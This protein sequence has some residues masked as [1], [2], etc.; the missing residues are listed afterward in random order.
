MSKKSIIIVIII[1]LL[2]VFLVLNK[3]LYGIGK[4]IYN[5]MNI[6]DTQVSSGNVEVVPVEHASLILKSGGKVIYVDPVYPKS[7]PSAFAGEPAPDLILIT[8]IHPDHF[9]IKTLEGVSKENT[10]IIAPMILADMFPTTVAGNLYIMK[11]GQKT[12]MQG[13]SIESMPMYNLP[14][15]ADSYHPKGRG[16]GYVV[17]IGGKRVYISGDTSATP[18]MRSLKNIDIAFICMNLP[19]TM[20]VEEASKGV[21]AFKPKQVYPY[22][23]RGTS[24]LSDVNKFKKLV[25]EVDPNIDV[26]LLNWYSK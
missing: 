11:N 2:G 21:L 7:G 16:N 6:S 13:F 14:Q 22:H 3:N 10:D 20:S 26:V 12:T 9:D 15:K 23:Y 1:L 25:N 4:K 8:D 19:Y 24:G 5:N 18:E 17:G